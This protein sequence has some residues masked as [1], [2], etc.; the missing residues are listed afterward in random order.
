MKQG[1]VF[2]IERQCLIKKTLSLNLSLSRNSKNS[3]KLISSKIMVYFHQWRHFN[4]YIT[5]NISTKFYHQERKKGPIFIFFSFWGNLK[6]LVQIR[7]RGIVVDNKR[8]H[9]PG[10]NLCVRSNSLSKSLHVLIKELKG[11]TKYITFSVP[12]TFLE[13]S[14]L[15]QIALRAS[16]FITP[17]PAKPFQDKSVFQN[18]LW[19]LT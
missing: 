14:S 2:S 8:I 12:K 17:L 15:S 1:T 19:W 7:L 18:D 16:F 11:G 13:W 4:P 6:S 9:C 3:N 5:V 10:S